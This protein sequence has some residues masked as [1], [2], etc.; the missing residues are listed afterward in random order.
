VKTEL[1]LV[2][3]KKGPVQRCCFLQPFLQKTWNGNLRACLGRV[4]FV[5]GW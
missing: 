4:Q 2:S 3:F 1:F 5:S